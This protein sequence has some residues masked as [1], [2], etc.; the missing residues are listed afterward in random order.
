M[1]AIHNRRGSFSDRWI[2]YCKKNSI[3]Y[4]LVDCYRSD[5]IQQLD[6]CDRLMWHW[7]H[8]DMAGSIVAKSLTKLIEDIGIK[9]FPSSSNSWHYDDKIAQKY[10]FEAYNIPHIPTEIFFSKESAIG[11]AE[12]A[13]YPLV[14]KL[15]R[16]A[17]SSNVKLLNSIQEARKAINKSFSK[18]WSD[19]SQARW[20]AL[21]NR[22]S[23]F[24]K[25]RNLESLLQISFGLGRFLFPKQPIGESRTEKGY[26]YFQKFVERN[27]FDIRVIVIG[28]KAI[29]IKR[30]VR[31]GDFRA[32]GSGIIEYDQSHIP[33]DCVRIAFQSSEKLS[34]TCLAYDFVFLSDGTPL[35]V[36]ISYAFSQDAYLKCP[37]YWDSSLTWHSS[38]C[39]TEHMMIEAFLE[40]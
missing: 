19:R 15:S 3:P 11:Y 27:S 10:I 20:H 13:N 7:P 24:R 16:G 6:G 23:R 31:P 32:S 9:V 2:E 35:V 33:E 28:R 1:I 17:G 30:Y 40:E 12:G 26:A 34:S 21:D 18:G 25:N 14:F 29:G 36:E 37:G 39:V 4:K 8:H 38:N 22:I 5:I